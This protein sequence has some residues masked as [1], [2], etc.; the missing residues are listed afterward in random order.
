MIDD[1][2]S[3]TVISPKATKPESAKELIDSDKYKLVGMMDEVVYTE[4]LK[5]SK[6]DMVSRNLRIMNHLDITVEVHGGITGD[7]LKIVGFDVEPKSIDWGTNPCGK[8]TTP[9]DPPKMIY[10]PAN[11]TA[12]DPPMNVHFTYSVRIKKSDLLWTHRFDHFAKQSGSSDQVHHTQF[13][14][15]V[16]IAAFLFWI[17]K[18]CMNKV[19]NKDLN[20]VHRNNDK[21]KKVRTSRKEHA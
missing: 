17:V 6:Y 3:A 13:I 11:E 8:F 20:Q 1:L 21:L 15:S 12:G 14:V 7:R 4:G 2:P 9:D 19:I 18:C 10:A 16:C 5:M